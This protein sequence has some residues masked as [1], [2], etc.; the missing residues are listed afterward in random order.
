[1]PK[2]IQL[3][4]VTYLT[5]IYLSTDKIVTLES[6]N[7]GGTIINLSNGEILTVTENENFILKELIPTPPATKYSTGKISKT[8][9]PDAGVDVYSTT[10][11]VIKAG[12]SE[13]LSTGLYLAIP[14]GHVGIVKSRSGLSVNYNLEVGAGVLD[15][16]FSNEVKIHL[17]NHGV[18]DYKVNIMDKIAQILILPVNL[19]PW[20]KVESLPESSRG[21]NGFG[22]TGGR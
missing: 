2:Y 1:M 20:E 16:G 4:E 7:S 22:S 13:V 8:H 12:F 3:T 18:M 19:T 21:M 11:V 15:V 17:Y 14:D 9:L 6:S 10:S 5:K